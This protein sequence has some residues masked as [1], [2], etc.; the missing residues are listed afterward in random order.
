MIYEIT[1]FTVQADKIAEVQQMIGEFIESIKQNEPEVL[2]YE[3]YQDH[4]GNRFFNLMCFKDRKSES[5]H[6]QAGHTLTFL[7]KLNPLCQN[8]PV[9]TTLDMVGK[10]E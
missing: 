4:G 6:Q 1:E 5:S 2:R 10:K 7:S 9:I 8:K 3:S